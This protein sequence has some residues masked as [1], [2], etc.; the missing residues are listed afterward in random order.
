MI[1]RYLVLLA[2]I[3]L[4]SGCASLSEGECRT[5]DWYDLGVRDGRG[6]EPASRLHEHHKACAEYGVRP[7]DRRYMDGRAEGLRDYCRLENAVRIG[8]NGQQYQGVCT[9][10]IDAEFRRHN[11]AAYDVYR[12]RKEIE[13]ADSSLAEKE[14][15]LREKKLSDEERGRIRQDI[16]DLDRKLER[17]RDELRDQERRLDRLMDSSRD[18]KNWR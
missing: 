7:L 11:E 8:L 1:V 18:R 3:A 16:R 12:L 4:L 2:G 10:A 15:R 14:R 9:S 5:A 6:G 17:L 13:S